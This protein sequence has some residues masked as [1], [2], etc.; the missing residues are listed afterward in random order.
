MCVV[1]VYVCVCDDSSQSAHLRQSTHLRSSLIFFVGCF[2]PMQALGFMHSLR[3]V[4]R[5]IKVSNICWNT[6]TKV[7]PVFVCGVWCG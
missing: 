2:D 1:D 5:D 3:I 7:C 4:H 6:N